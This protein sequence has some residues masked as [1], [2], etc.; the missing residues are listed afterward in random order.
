MIQNIKAYLW[1]MVKVVLWLELAWL[2]LERGSLIFI[3]D[4]I[5][6]GRW[7]Q[8]FIGTLFFHPN[9]LGIT[10]SYNDLNSTD[11]STKEFIRGIKWKVL[12]RTSQST[13]L[14]T[15]LSKHFTSWRGNYWEKPQKK[16][17]IITAWCSYWKQGICKYLVSFALI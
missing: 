8:K 7:I 11:N 4:V 13:D 16:Q 15:Q 14:P 12:D 17:L 3:Y 1:N 2:F 6:D 9:Y 5:H 10:F